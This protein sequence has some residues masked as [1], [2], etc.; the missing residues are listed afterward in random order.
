METN[1]HDDATC[2][3]C[4][5]TLS[6]GTKPEPTCWK[7]YYLCPDCG[8]EVMAGRIAREGVSHVDEMWERAERLGSRWEG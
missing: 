5:A 3:R 7:V 8:W 6:Y 2:P 1:V 4:R